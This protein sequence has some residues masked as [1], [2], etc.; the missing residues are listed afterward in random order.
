M[1]TN[2][3]F[4]DE[5]FRILLKDFAPYIAMELQKKYNKDWWNLGVLDILYDGKKFDLPSSGTWEQLVDSLD[6]QRCLILYDNHWK[7]IFSENQSPLIKSWAKELLSF[8]NALAHLGGKDFSSEDA[9]RALD[10]LARFGKQIGDECYEELRNLKKKFLTGVDINATKTVTKSDDILK[11]TSSGLPSWRDIMIPHQDVRQGNYKTAEFAASL[12]QVLRGGEPIY[13]DPKMFFERTF[14]TE[15]I[16][17]L[18][19]QAIRRV[20]GNDGDPVIQ[21]KTAFGGGKTHSM[22]ALYHLL[23]GKIALEDISNIDKVMEDA[24]VSALLKVNIAVIVG[25]DF[26]PAESSKSRNFDDVRINTIW[27]EIADQLAFNTKNPALFDYVREADKKGVSPGSVV[28]QNLFDACAPCMVLMDEP[29]AYAKK[30]YGKNDLPAGTFDNFITFIQELTEAAKA[31]KNSLVVASIPESKA[32]VGEKSGKIALEAIEHHFGRM[33][34]VW[35]PVAANEGFEVVRRRLFLDCKSEEQKELI[36]N[37]FSQMYRD[38]ENDFPVEAKEVEYR[39]RMLSCYP[40]HPEIFDRLYGDWSTLLK[41]QR[42]RGVLRLMAAVIHKLWMSNDT[43]PM[44][45]AGSIT[46]NESAIREEFT[47]ALDG[48]GWNSIIDNEIDG[49][50]SIPYHKD[51]ENSR[52]GAIM[53]SRRISRTIFLGSAPTS[54]GQNIRGV[55]KEHI[56]LGAILPGENI[57][58]F[59]D[60]IGSLH[61]SLAYLYSD[62][63]SNRFW[64]DTRPTLRKTIDGRETQITDEEIN[65]EIT[66]MLRRIFKK[67]EPFGG[68]HVCPTSTLDIIDDQQLRLIVLPPKDNFRRVSN[69]DAAIISAENFVK[70]H[71]NS[72]RTNQNRLLFAAAKQDELFGFKTI[73]KHHLALLSV[74]GDRNLN[75]DKEQISWLD[76]EIEPSSKKVAETL[77]QTYQVALVPEIDKNTNMKTINW[78]NVKFSGAD[79]VLASVMN[80]GL[81]YEDFSSQIFINKMND[82]SASLWKEGDFVRIDDLWNYFCTYLWLPRLKNYSVL[83]NVIRKCAELKKFALAKDK[84]CDKYTDLKYTGYFDTNY[85]LVKFDVAEKQFEEERGDTPDD[86]DENKPPIGTNP[87]AIDPLPADPVTKRPKTHFYMTKNLEV[88]RI[89]RDVN[90]LYNEVIANLVELKGSEVKITLEVSIDSPNGIPQNIIRTVLEN[91]NNLKVDDFDFSE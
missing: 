5:G 8:R 36:V 61:S 49:T 89:N 87:P 18:L 24:K 88:T 44:I 20:T 11:T 82:P 84:E 57:S 91:C 54:R 14:V 75:L 86:S 76:K 38:N 4:V 42:T 52:Y 22:L 69:D 40:I 37:K 48:G 41:F 25:T 78:D 64:F 81:V 50:D 32:E 13:T 77:V 34:T 60:V 67:K 33:E 53:A 45:M 3:K 47:K 23:N 27:G 63:V 56:R 74:R 12:S 2:Y 29:A 15:G 31:S 16:R 65:E 26:N 39:N 10:T 7:T 80:A 85:L 6:I 72:L 62:S 30:L 28:L 46:L 19:S 17:G 55:D 90:E 43:S 51:S 73:L 58:I 79:N 68:V 59:N 83:E 71:G 66:K 9:E 70:N 35:K 1:S 21:I